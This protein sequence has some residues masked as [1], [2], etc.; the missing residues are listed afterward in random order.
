MRKRVLRALLGLSLVSVF[1]LGA[2]WLLTEKYLVVRNVSPSEPLGWYL[3]ERTKEVKKGDLI[4]FYFKGSKIA[5][6][7]LIFLKEIVCAPGDK[8]EVKGKSFYCNGNFLGKALS[9]SCKRHIQVKTFHWNGTIPEGE[10]FVMGQD[11]CSYDSRY[12]GF[13][14]E[15]QILGKEI[16]KLK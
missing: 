2:K 12:W 6:K 15:K 1:Y 9:Y 8:L 5:P 4:A 11:R 16:I 7:G 10:Y 3:F 14:K 13:V